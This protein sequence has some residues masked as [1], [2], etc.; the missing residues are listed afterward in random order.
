MKYKLLAADMDGTLLNDASVITKRT[1]SALRAAIARG[2]L[3]VPSTGR[4][5]CAMEPVRGVFE[6]D[7]PYILFNG[8]MVVMRKSGKVLFEQSL[9]FHCAEEIF[10][11]AIR[12]NFP[13]VA[14]AGERLF[15]SCAYE[16]VRDYRAVSGA[17]LH[18]INSIEP[19]RN[20]GVTKMLWIMPDAVRYQSEMRALFGS[21][22][23]CFASRPYY[24]EFVDAKA[25]KGLALR[26]IGEAYGIDRSEMI[27]VGDG[28]NDVPM[29]EF[30]GLSVAMGN[31]PTDIQQLCRDV[32]LTN[33][34]DGVAAVIEKYILGGTNV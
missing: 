20:Q 13:V 17:E 5:M 23:N 10:A 28:Y 31:A 24:L 11:Q 4:P 29:L 19:L 2:V 12:L 1:Q 8:A 34:E 16:E 6:E 22:V 26:A 9:D 32:T 21:T 30:A 7:L 15:A 27:A 14:W 18:V 33:E 3:F 25:S